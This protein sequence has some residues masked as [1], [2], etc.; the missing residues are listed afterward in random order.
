MEINE[1]K[2]GTISASM[3]H[4]SDI[5]DVDDPMSL[6]A[7]TLK[8]IEEKIIPKTSAVPEHFNKL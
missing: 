3:W 2:L 8:D 5:T 4:Q 7:S 1:C 6:F